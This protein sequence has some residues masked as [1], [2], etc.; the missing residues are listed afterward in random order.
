M[1]LFLRMEIKKLDNV[2]IW[3]YQFDRRFDTI[4]REWAKKFPNYS[5]QVDY[6]QLIPVQGKFKGYRLYKIRRAGNLYE[7]EIFGK[8]KIAALKAEN[9]R[10]LIQ[11]T[12]L[13]LPT[14]ILEQ[15]IARRD[16]IRITIGNQTAT[17]NQLI[18]FLRYGYGGKSSDTVDLTE[19]DWE[20]FEEKE[21]END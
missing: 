16:A 9:S 3:F 20:K 8:G 17:L 19:I 5:F 2:L 12:L 4:L 7:I 15:F 6:K 14:S 11:R 21:N 1:R 10:D 13:W 18:I